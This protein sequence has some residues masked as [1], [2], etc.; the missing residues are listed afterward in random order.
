MSGTFDANT[1]LTVVL[2]AR[3]WNSL[4]ALAGEGMTSL[5]S[6]M[7]EV[8]R[9]CMAQPREPLPEHMPGRVGGGLHRPNGEAPE[10]T[11]V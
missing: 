11:G 4:L 9:Q 8:Q 6:I 10:E 7:A 5:G 3:Q 1:A 2:P